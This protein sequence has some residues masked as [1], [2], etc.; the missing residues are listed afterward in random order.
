MENKM[1]VPVKA[2]PNVIVFEGSREREKS[3]PQPEHHNERKTSAMKIFTKDQAGR[4]NGYVLPLWSVLEY[5]EYRPDQVYVTAV[6]PLS[7]KGPHLHMKRRGMFFCVSGIVNIVM[8]TAFGTYVDRLLPD[9]KGYCGPVTVP[10]GV[11]CAIYNAYS[12]EALVINMPSPAWSAEDPD[13]WPV[14]NWEDQV[15]LPGRT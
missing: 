5:P 1:R 8:R 9:A 12:T 4:S 3:D 6:A 13:E 14:E 15:W 10:P 7:R 2:E 11:P